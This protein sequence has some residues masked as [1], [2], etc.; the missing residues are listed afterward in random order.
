[1]AEQLTLFFFG[2]VFFVILSWRSFKHPISHGFFRFFGFE[3]CLILVVINMPFWFKNPW[4]MRQILSWFFLLVSILS[5]LL[6]FLSLCKLGEQRK[7]DNSP[8]TYTFE[9]TSRLIKVGVYRYIR[10]PMYSSFIFLAGGGWL[11]HI[12]WLTSIMALLIIVV[13]IITAKIEERENTN[14]F[15]NEYKNYIKETKMFIPFL[16]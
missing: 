1:M 10:H 9:E 12:S 15:G 11:K 3:F 16:I 7:R 2:T 5:V 14:F 6:G 4:S 8:E 13:T